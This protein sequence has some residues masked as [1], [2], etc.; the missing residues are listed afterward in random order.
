MAGNRNMGSHLLHMLVYSSLVSAFLA[1]LFR[2]EKQERI[3][4][5]SLLWVAMVGGAITLAWVMYPFP[6]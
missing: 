6:R 2:D 1:V 4:F 5:G 3:R